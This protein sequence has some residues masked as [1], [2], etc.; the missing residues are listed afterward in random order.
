MT[1]SVSQ[2]TSLISGTPPSVSFASIVPYG[3]LI[4]ACITATTFSA[5]T[6][7][8]NVNAR[9][10]SQIAS[11]LNTGA[12]RYLRTWAAIANASGAP[13]VTTNL[14]GDQGFLMALDVTG[15]MGTPTQD[16]IIGSAAGTTGTTTSVSVSVTSNFNNEIVV[17]S[18]YGVGQTLSGISGGWTEASGSSSNGYLF[19]QTVP[20]PTTVTLTAT[21]SEAE[22]WG[23][24]AW[25]YYDNPN[26][27][28]WL[29]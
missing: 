8:D 9:G 11:F 15:F 19:Y 27:S 16:S 3:D 26:A 21:L 14:S 12:S 4:L 6:T 29:T 1:L 20:T 13:T 5:G 22:D 28:A 24:L 25:G 2:S 17:I 18:F 7:T 10:Y 23:A